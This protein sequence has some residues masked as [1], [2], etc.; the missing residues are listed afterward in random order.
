MTLRALAVLSDGGSVL[1][2]GCA[3]AD[4]CGALTAAARVLRRARPAVCARAESRGSAVLALAK[5]LRW[6]SALLALAA[7]RSECGAALREVTRALAADGLAVRHAPL[8]PEEF[9]RQPDG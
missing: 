8:S 3:G 7:P 2:A 4:V 9:R 6:R 5:R 1:S